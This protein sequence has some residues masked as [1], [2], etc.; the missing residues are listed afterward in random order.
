MT[1]C[2][3]TLLNEA[4]EINEYECKTITGVSDTICCT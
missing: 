3:L 4:R 2:D 1:K